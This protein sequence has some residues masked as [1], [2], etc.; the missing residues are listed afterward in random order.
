MA[1]H[2]VCG[3]LWFASREVRSAPILFRPSLPES[4][5]VGCVDDQGMPCHE[6]STM[7]LEFSCGEL[8]VRVGVEA[9]G[10]VS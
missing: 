6:Q 1:V 5:R 9:L 7:V 8:G 2:G 4:P 10:R 3:I